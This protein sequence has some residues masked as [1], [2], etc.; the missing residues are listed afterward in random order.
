MANLHTSSTP[1]TKGKTKANRLCLWRV[2]KNLNINQQKNT[3]G[4]FHSAAILFLN[5]QVYRNQSEAHLQIRLVLFQTYFFVM[6]I[7]CI[8][9]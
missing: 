3:S 6:V 1:D 5:T 7:F 8:C 9:G 4:L 2:S